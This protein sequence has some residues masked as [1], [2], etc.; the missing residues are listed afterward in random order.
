MRRCSNFMCSTC[1]VHFCV[2]VHG[3][4]RKTFWKKWYESKKREVL[5]TVNNESRIQKKSRCRK[6]TTQIASDNDNDEIVA[7]MQ[8]CAGRRRIN[9]QKSTLVDHNISSFLS[10]ARR[11]QIQDGQTAP[12]APTQSASHKDTKKIHFLMF[13]PIR[14]FKIK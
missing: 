13:K 3:D 2:L 9:Q 1:K 4:K 5:Q 14:S 7:N 11:P 10:S 6:L 8:R 12:R